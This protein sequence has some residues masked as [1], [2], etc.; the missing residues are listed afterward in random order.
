MSSARPLTCRV[1][2]N[3][4]EVWRFGS[5]LRRVAG[6]FWLP[7]RE[8]SGQMA[9]TNKIH[10]LV[11]G[12]FH[13]SADLVKSL[14]HEQVVLSYM[15]DMPEKCEV[16]ETEKEAYIRSHVRK[17]K[18]TAEFPD[19]RKSSTSP[20]QFR[21][22]GGS[23]QE[24]LERKQSPYP[25]KPIQKKFWTRKRRYNR[26][27]PEEQGTRFDKVFHSEVQL[28]NQILSELETKEYAV[29]RL[30]GG[31][32]A[33]QAPNGGF[34][35][36]NVLRT[37]HGLRQAV[38]EHGELCGVF[39]NLSYHT[40]SSREGTIFLSRVCEFLGQPT[41][42]GKP[43]LCFSKP[44]PNVQARFPGV[45]LSH[46][47]IA[48][49]HPMLQPRLLA[50]VPVSER[51][52]GAG[53]VFRSVVLFQEGHLT[54]AMKKTLAELQEVGARIVTQ[55]DF[56]SDLSSYEL[57]EGTAR[58]MEIVKRVNVSAAVAVMTPLWLSLMCIKTCKSFE[59]I[60]AA[61]DQRQM[62][63]RK[64]I[65]EVVSYTSTSLFSRSS[66]LCES[67][68]TLL[69]D[70]VSCCMRTHDFKSTETLAEVQDYRLILQEVV[71]DR[72]ANSTCNFILKETEIAVTFPTD[73]L[74]NPR[75]IEYAR[76]L[77]DRI[78]LM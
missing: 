23:K 60:L 29:S 74:K 73:L 61:D 50:K 67:E 20:E 66:S 51:A 11:V 16:I 9:A 37:Y 78:M 30:L 52:T 76:M 15:E 77:D 46:I 49:L 41:S 39:V 59:S 68:V 38:S 56:F 2:R 10:L 33:N 45:D 28:C 24:E 48:F 13:A 58:V 5:E 72:K 63:I 32:G 22:R 69:E 42:D 57:D 26:Y 71:Q 8:Q 44:M 35:N 34:T 54:K 64:A 40:L 6:Y 3:K 31:R 75:I 53:A 65:T 19:T 14:E 36:I 18:T 12:S 47:E 17:L 21:L 27:G 7:D 43:F 25:A 55:D 1:E 62:H 70:W 4:G